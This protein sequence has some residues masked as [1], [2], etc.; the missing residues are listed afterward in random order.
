MPQPF[1]LG[2]F[3]NA[4]FNGITQPNLSGKRHPES[5]GKHPPEG[6]RNGSMGPSSPPN[7][8]LRCQEKYINNLYTIHGTGIYDTYILVGFLW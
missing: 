4:S 6:S 2:P 8:K 3:F 5:S 7:E 1:H